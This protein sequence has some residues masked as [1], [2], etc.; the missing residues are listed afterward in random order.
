M[1]RF[2]VEVEN[3]VYTGTYYGES[4]EISEMNGEALVMVHEPDGSFTAHRSV[5]VDSI[6]LDE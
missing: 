1:A 3:D 6:E 4:V 2:K 5:Y